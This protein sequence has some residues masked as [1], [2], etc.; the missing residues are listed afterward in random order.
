[1]KYAI[2]DKAAAGYLTKIEFEL[3][4]S[5]HTQFEC[6]YNEYI[7]EAQLLDTPKEAADVIV[8]IESFKFMDKGRFVIH[9]FD[10]T[11]KD[12]YIISNAINPTKVV[13]NITVNLEGEIDVKYGTMTS[14][15]S[16]DSLEYAIVRMNALQKAKNPKYTA[17]CNTFDICKVI[18]VIDE[19]SCTHYQFINVT[20]KGL[21]EYAK[22]E[23]DPLNK[24]IEELKNKYEST[25]E[26][27]ELLKDAI[28]IKNKKIEKLEKALDNQKKLNDDDKATIARMVI[29]KRATN[30]E[31]LDWKLRAEEAIRNYTRCNEALG[32]WKRKCK[33][34]DAD[35]AIISNKLKSCEIVLESTQACLTEMT[36]KRDKALERAEKYKGRLNSIYGYHDT[37]DAAVE[38]CLYDYGIITG[39][40]CCGKQLMNDI[41]SG[42][43]IPI[44]KEKYDDLV[45]FTNNLNSTYYDTLKWLGISTN[46]P[47]WL[48]GMTKRIKNLTE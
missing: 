26:N 6:G 48:D 29:E 12:Q 39:G 3:G 19:K 9:S 45:E 13:D 16:T 40:R 8:R 25:T 27:C 24:R 37:D 14:H 43:K 20:E 5:E 10:D 18:T 7:T 30:R 2:Y 42:K 32:E 34:K 33:A 21:T 4:C 1:M 38:Y 11:L 41:L 28:D 46:K 31:L 15:W 44:N 23:V 17:W 22:N 47:V 35:Y 36:N